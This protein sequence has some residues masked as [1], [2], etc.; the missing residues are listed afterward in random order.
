MALFS[1]KNELAALQA[2]L[3]AAERRVEEKEVQIAGLQQRLAESDAAFATLQNEHKKLE[4]TIHNLQ[5]FSKSLSDVQASLS[6][7]ANNMRSEKDRAVEAQGVSLTSSDA[8]ERISRNLS[9]LASSSFQAAQ[10]VGSLDHLSQEIIGVVGLIKE[11]ADQTNL[12]ALNAS[13][14]AARAGESGRGFAVVADEVRKLAERT[15]KATTDISA[16]VDSIRTNSGKSSTQMS[17]LAEQSKA[18]SD[19]GQQATGT[20]RELMRLSVSMEQVIAASALRSF[21]ELAKIDH[22]IYKFEIYRVIFGLSQKPASEFAQHT[23]CRLGKWYYEGEGRDCFSQL[24]GYREVEDPH[25][26]VHQ[27]AI[28]ALAAHA[29]G[30]VDV[31]LRNV[32]KMEEA[33]LNVLGNLEKMAESGELS[34]DLLCTH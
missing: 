6:K 23:Q 18:Y 10:Q 7:L 19:E 13:I 14:E 1:K 3:A 5:N 24:P 22:L 26:I 12:L 2:Q 29:E 28:A 15:A 33:S 8:I 16:L 34:P 11:I 25:K 20:M 4:G 27:S 32:G 31:M 21:C 9:E 17:S 30:N